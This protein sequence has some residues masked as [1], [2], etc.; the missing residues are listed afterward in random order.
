MNATLLIQWFKTLLLWFVQNPTITAPIVGATIT[1]IW[2]PRTPQQYALMATRYPTWLWMRVAAFLQLIAALFPDP[3]KAKKVVFKLIYGDIDPIDPNTGGKSVPPPSTKKDVNL[4]RRIKMLAATCILLVA[5]TKQQLLGAGDLFLQKVMCAISHS[6]LPN[7][8][9]IEAC[10]VQ[11]GD[12]N[13][14]LEIVGE[15][16]KDAALKAANE[17]ARAV[18]EDRKSRAGCSGPKDGGL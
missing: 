14:I 12:V 10:A 6:D 8:K 1:L 3:I 17:A 4:Q 9:I 2:K 5:C 18:Q 11:P 16:R 13:R 7:E 15:H